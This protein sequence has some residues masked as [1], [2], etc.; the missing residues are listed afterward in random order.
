MM[1]NGFP[2]HD[3]KS[4]APILDQAAAYDVAYIDCIVV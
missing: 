3:G 4:G 1:L 2:F